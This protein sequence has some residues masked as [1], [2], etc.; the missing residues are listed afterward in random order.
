MTVLKEIFTIKAEL[1]TTANSAIAP[2]TVQK[3][4]KTSSIKTSFKHNGDEN[5][6]QYK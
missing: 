4:K 2:T 3:K 5:G 6:I 1:T